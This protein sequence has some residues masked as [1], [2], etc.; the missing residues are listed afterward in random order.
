ME[1]MNSEEYKQWMEES[2]AGT[3]TL[4]GTDTDWLDEIFE[5][6]PMQKHHLSFSGGSEK[7]SYMISGSYY[8]QNGIVGDDKAKYERFTAR[9]NVKSQLK[10]WLEVGNNF[11]FSHSKQK[12][13]G[14]DDEYRS[15][16]N[17]ALLIDPL[18]PITYDGTP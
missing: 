3:V 15:V 14:E 7:T 10:D 4:N 6:A 5:V 18:T 13:I 2:G 9:A 1:V 8:T 17:N 11:S 12:Y 16:V